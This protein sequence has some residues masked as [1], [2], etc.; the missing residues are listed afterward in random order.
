M[1]KGLLICIYLCSG[2]M[3]GQATYITEDASI[4]F[5]ASTPL[6]DIVA[7][8]QKVNMI[9]KS[10]G[11]LAALLL[12]KEF[13][14][15]RALMQEHFNE[16]YMESDKYPKAYFT[17]TIENFSGEELTEDFKAFPISG[18]LTIHG[19]TKPFTASIQMNRINNTVNLQS[20]FILYPE[21]FKIKVPR[22]LFKKI[23]REINVSLTSELSPQ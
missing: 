18:S 21:E 23:A 22:L 17:G 1:K 4:N 19:V 20:D 9:L 3:L 8:N 5:D 12:I 6:E 16:N 11:E 7:K 10:N 15:K 2:L 13:Q 14:F